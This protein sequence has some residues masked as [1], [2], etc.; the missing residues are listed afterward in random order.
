M[1]DHI[2]RQAVRTSSWVYAKS[3]W[4][5]LRYFILGVIACFWIPSW[6]VFPVVVMCYFKEFTFIKIKQVVSLN[7][8][9]VWQVGLIIIMSN[10]VAANQPFIA[11]LF[12][13]SSIAQACVVSF[14]L[15][16]MLGSS[17]KYA[18]MIVILVN[19][20]GMAYLPLILA[21]EFTGYLMSPIHKC[22]FITL[23]TFDTS[24]KLFYAKT[25]VLGILL[26]ATGAY[27]SMNLMEVTL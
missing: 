14:L 12:L 18:G 17:S 7:W 11:S 1:R 26:I 16:F 3:L 2:E 6:L 4:L 21:V 8:N 9:I 23:Q 15:S 19:I 20:Y 27:V 24:A 5:K 13:S 25:F 10:L 22:V